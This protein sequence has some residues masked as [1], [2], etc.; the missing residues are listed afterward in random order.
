MG[1]ENFRV[2]AQSN[3]SV[4]EV[5]QHLLALDQ[6]TE[7]NSYTPRARYLELRTER[8]LFEVEVWMDGNKS[9]A[10]FSVTVC[11]PV[12]TIDALT[13]L[14]CSLVATLDVQ[15]ISIMEE[16]ADDTVG[17]FDVHSWKASL[18]LWRGLLSSRKNT[19]TF[20]SV[21]KRQP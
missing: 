5:T 4:D 18:N 17:D 9:H 16:L 7:R 1:A 11:H 21:Q 10:V 6:S 19:G 8:G 12:D 15:S 14:I 2:R 3:L 20:S 13:R